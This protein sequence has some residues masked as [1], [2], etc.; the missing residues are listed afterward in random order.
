MA[1]TLKFPQSPWVPEAPADPV[2]RTD[3]SAIAAA[4]IERLFREHNDSLLRFLT[5]RLGSSHEAKEVAQEAYVRLLNLHQPDAVSYLRAFLFKTAA[6]LAID[7]LRTRQLR[8]HHA[9]LD[10][11]N[12]L[13]DAPSAERE[14]AGIQDLSVLQR[15]IDELPVKCRR[16]FILNRFQGIDIDAIACDMHTTERNVRRYILQALVHCRLGLDAAHGG[17]P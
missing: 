2:A 3:A 16:A 10:F 14:V 8:E 13:R 6:N 9:S 12:T 7:R 15:L 1:H 11:F 5:A 17:A 4:T